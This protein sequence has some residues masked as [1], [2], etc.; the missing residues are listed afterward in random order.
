M[1]SSGGNDAKIT[2]D[3]YW[4]GV[5]TNGRN[6]GN[7]ADG[8][9]GREEKKRGVTC[10]HPVTHRPPT[11]RSVASEFGPFRTL[12]T[13]GV[14]RCLCGISVAHNSLMCVVYDLYE[15]TALWAHM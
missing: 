15:S 6:G 13:P 9:R 7:N 5:Y 11:Q 8:S 4:Q 12:R 2:G 1:Y 14:T 3:G 10:R